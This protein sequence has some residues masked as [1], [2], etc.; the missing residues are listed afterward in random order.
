MNAKRQKLLLVDQS[1]SV[2]TETKKLTSSNV[3]YVLS[4]IFSYCAVQMDALLVHDYGGRSEQGSP[5]PDARSD[6]R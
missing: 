4:P 2:P 1:F 5:G 6:V 3:F